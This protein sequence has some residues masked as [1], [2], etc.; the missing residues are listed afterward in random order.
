MAVF[1]EKCQRERDCCTTDVVC[2]TQITH[3]PLS[4]FVM[5]SFYFILFQHMCVTQLRQIEMF[6]FLSM[7]NVFVCVVSEGVYLDDFADVQI[8]IENQSCV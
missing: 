3:S 5:G 1:T 4:K 7:E 8:N 2:F 6:F